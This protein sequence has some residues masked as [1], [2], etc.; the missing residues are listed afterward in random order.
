[1]QFRIR[2]PS[3]LLNK[4]ETFSAIFEQPCSC[5]P[6]F[7]TGN[8]NWGISYFQM[9]RAEDPE[10]NFNW[11][12]ITIGFPG[13]SA[14]DVE[15]RIND[16]I[17][18]SIRR[19]VQDIRFINSTSRDGVSN[20]LI[21]FEQ[22]DPRDFDKRVID[23]RREVQTT[24]T[25][26]LPEESSDP[27]IFEVT[28]SNSLP[29]AMIVITGPGGDENLRRQARNI[30]KDLE[31][32][33]GGDSVNS[34]GLS[35]SEIHVAFYP[36]RLEGLG[37]TPIDL[38]E[39]VR[40]YIRDVSVGDVDTKDIKWIVRLE[41]TN[42]D[43]G[44]L[45]EF[46]IVTSKGVVT[47]GSL[48]DIFRTTKEPSAI[49]RFNDNPAVTMGIIK[50]GNTNVLNLLD[51]IS[52]Y[53]DGR[54][55]S[56]DRTGVK[57]YLVDDQT[58]STRHAI[59]LMQNNAVIGLIMVLLATWA[60]LGTRIALL[61]SIA[62]PFT[63]AGTFII[64][65]NI[66]ES[67]NNTVL[68]GVVI[69]LGMLVDDAVVVEAIYYRL[70]RG[71]HGMQAAISAL[72][73]VFAPVT[74]SVMTTI[75]AFLPL[76]LLPGILGDFMNVIPLVVTLTLIFSL[77]EAYWMLTAH[78]IAA[79]I[80]FKKKSTAQLKR[81]TITHWVRLKYTWFLLKTF[82]YPR[83]SVESILLV[84]FLAVGTFVTGHIRF[85]FFEFD[86]TQ[87][88]YINVE[89]PQG[90][91][92]LETNEKLLEAKKMV[93][94][95]IKPEELRATV[96]YSGLMY[97]ATEP[98]FGDSIGQVMVSLNSKVPK[99]RSST[100]IVKVMDNAITQIEDVDNIYTFHVA[101]G[102]PASK[103]IQVKIRGDEF[104]EIKKVAD[105]L[106]SYL[107]S[108]PFYRNV[109]FDCRPGNPELGLR[110]NGEAIKR[111]GIH[112]TVISRTL[113]A[114]VDGEIVTEFKDQGEEVKVRVLSNRERWIVLM[115]S[116]AR[117]SH[118]RTDGRLC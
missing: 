87:L 83:R 89:M 116:F 56:A 94:Q 24:Y 9:P 6:G 14:P 112:P 66:G 109:S 91:S 12:N 86:P 59:S 62:I 29:S 98:L 37:I 44:V 26:E 11:I 18:N 5:Q 77:V 80:N 7:R 41:G 99:G 73:E 50:K 32:I 31:R 97:T 58:D 46:P 23:L 13:A 85:N 79:K 20:I 1:M 35:D 57:L 34:L 39:T 92:L 16:P 30:E 75:S 25:D 93:L 118:Y 78:I 63:L 106:K 74:T 90:T 100:E 48:A 111:T 45:A 84:F 88:F 76:M 68:L 70:Q 38:T 114:Y 65:F 43:P 28:S 72:Q 69:A 17:E 3:I 15:R 101:D 103:A 67:L 107:N 61:T 82:R 113:Q 108:Q 21:R 47:L 10:V 4:H 71:M 42:T 105:A 19:S 104:A 96:V 95:H 36:E 2:L 27:F 64:L 55:L 115:I 52:E 117:P 54:N 33:S 8:N 81:E 102:P 51:S 60:F 40:G 53:I 49:V 22:I 110:Y